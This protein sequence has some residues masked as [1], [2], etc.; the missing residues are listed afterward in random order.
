MH[1]TVVCIGIVLIQKANES[2][3]FIEHKQYVYR[4]G[5]L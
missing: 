4:I 1:N 3:T 5:M 2:G